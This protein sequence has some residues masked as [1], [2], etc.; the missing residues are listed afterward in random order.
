M[1]Y[2]PSGGGAAILYFG[3]DTIAAGADKRFLTFGYTNQSAQTTPNGSWRAPRDGVLKN[4]RV[5]HNS[6]AGNGNAVVYDFDINTVAQGLGLSLVTN[7]IGDAS[8]LVTKIAISAGDL[9]DATAT[10]AAS[11]GSGA[12]EVAFVC[13]FE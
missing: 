6:S 13:E 5:R 7:A 4:F 12:Q 2:F 1:S 3:N 8:D 9:I 10:K 11:I